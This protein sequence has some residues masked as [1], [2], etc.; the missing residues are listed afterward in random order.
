MLVFI[1][2]FSGARLHVSANHARFRERLGIDIST[3]SH[4]R[5]LIGAGHSQIVDVPSAWGVFLTLRRVA[6]QS[7]LKEGAEVRQ[8]AR[9]FGVSERSLRHLP[10][11]A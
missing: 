7:A 9:K 11:Q 10:P 1:R 8:I 3:S 2:E 4:R 5:I 6:I